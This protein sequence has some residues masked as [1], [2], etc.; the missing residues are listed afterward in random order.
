MLKL[1]EK[2]QEIRILLEI[3]DVLIFEKDPII[4][5]FITLIEEAR[6]RLI[7]STANTSV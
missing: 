5:V 2:F 3:K 4:N 7:I 6:I 1:N